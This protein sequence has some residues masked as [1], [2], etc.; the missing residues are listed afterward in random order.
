MRKATA[1]DYEKLK[2]KTFVH[3]VKKVSPSMK[4]AFKR[5]DENESSN[6]KPGSIKKE[7]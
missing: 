1:E 5:S 2:N 3:F 6:E 7:R 4:K